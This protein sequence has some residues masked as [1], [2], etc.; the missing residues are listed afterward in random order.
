METLRE[1]I[2]QHLHSSD[3]NSA[4]KLSHEILN[5][6]EKRIELI[7]H[8]KYCNLCDDDKFKELEEMLKE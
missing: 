4:T 7:K 1:E 5:L 6:I 8:K 3:S 2:E